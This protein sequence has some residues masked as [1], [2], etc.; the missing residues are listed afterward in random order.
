VGGAVAG[1]D[2]IGTHNFIRNTIEYR[3]YFT[4]QGPIGRDFEATR[5][6]LAVRIKAGTI[7]GTVPYFEQFFAGGADTL[8]GYAEDRFWGRNELLT[9][10]EL[11]YPLQKAFSVIGFVD[12]GDAWGGYETVNTYTQTPTMQMHVGYGAGVSFKTP[13]GPIRVDLGFDD[14]GKSRTHFLIGTS[15]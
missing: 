4:D 12:W 9:T 11:R 13:L 3:R 6:V 8:R 10:A 2:V 1:A 15:F 5:R 14:R 7:S